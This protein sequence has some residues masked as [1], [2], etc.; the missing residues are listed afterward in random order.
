MGGCRIFV[1]MPTNP[2]HVF[3]PMSTSVSNSKTI[4]P[5]TID[6]YKYLL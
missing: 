1:F 3:M 4:K 2:T 6:L 5:K